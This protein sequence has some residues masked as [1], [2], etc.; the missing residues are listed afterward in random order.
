MGSINYTQVQPLSIHASK[1]TLLIKV[2][3]TIDKS[4]ILKDVPAQ[5]LNGNPSL[6]KILLKP[7]LDHIA[8]LGKHIDKSEVR[9]Y[10]TEDDCDVFAG[11]YGLSVN[12]K[13]TVS[14][15]DLKP[16]SQPTLMLNL[17]LPQQITPNRQSK[18]SCEDESRQQDKR[19]TP[20]ET[21]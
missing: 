11:I 7:I 8:F 20:E 5:Y 19:S 1:A 3:L 21:I 9:Y 2:K 14:L 4:E 17:K 12:E 13:S 18:S 16:G 6:G 15:E 10:S